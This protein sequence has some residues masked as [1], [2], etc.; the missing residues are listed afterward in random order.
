MIVSLLRRAIGTRV[1]QELDASIRT[2]CE[3]EGISIAVL[4]DVDVENVP[5]VN[6]LDPQEVVIRHHRFG[7][8]QY[9]ARISIPNDADRMSRVKLVAIKL[10]IGSALRK[11]TQDSGRIKLIAP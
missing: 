1:Q 9:E 8:S 4:G 3:K 6:L 10:L 5:V 7:I 11:L 2:L